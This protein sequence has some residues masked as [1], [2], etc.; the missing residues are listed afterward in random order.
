[1]NATRQLPQTVD[2]S[3]RLVSRFY[4]SNLR[5]VVIGISGLASLWALLLAIGSFKLHS[6]VGSGNI[7]HLGIIALI[8]GIL[9]MVG[10]AIELF[11]VIA[12][13]MQR[14][15]MVKAFAY[16][17][18]LSSI[19]ILGG[20]MTQIVVHFTMKNNLIN[21]CTS[22][23]TG[24]VVY[25]GWGILGPSRQTTLSANEAK[26]WCNDAWNHDSWADIVIFVI[27]LLLAILFV[28]IVFAYYRQ[29]IDPTSPVNA[30][31]MPLS[32]FRA[33]GYPEQYNPPYTN[34]PFYPPP[35]GPPP[36]HGDYDQGFV[37][38][39]DENKLPDYGYQGYYTEDK[40]DGDKGFH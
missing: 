34:G 36:N 22:A 5:P 8:L 3:G 32:Q 18:I 23:T 14:A 37:P 4:K 12:A 35:P 13:L 30:S 21:E 38:P 9:F 1:M 16:L 11:G 15:V 31:R 33:E 24:D 40:K 19:L 7:P 39:Y 20:N 25:Y 29:V 10:L 6:D 26:I 27:E 17:S 2:S 28:S